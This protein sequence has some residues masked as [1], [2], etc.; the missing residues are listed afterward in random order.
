MYLYNL[1]PSY[2]ATYLGNPQPPFLGGLDLFHPGTT[3]ESAIKVP[4]R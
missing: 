3:P 2:D 1:F 4:T